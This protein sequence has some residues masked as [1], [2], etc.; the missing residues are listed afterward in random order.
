MDKRLVICDYFDIKDLFIKQVV[1]DIVKPGYL[2]QIIE[3]KDGIHLV[4]NEDGTDRFIY[5]NSL[6]SNKDLRYQ[7]KFT[8]VSP[9]NILSF[10]SEYPEKHIEFISSDENPMDKYKKEI[11][12][13]SL[14]ELDQP[15]EDKLYSLTDEEFII[16]MY[17]DL[18]KSDQDA[19]EGLISSFEFTSEA[20]NALESKPKNETTALRRLEKHIEQYKETGDPIEMGLAQLMMY[21]MF[22]IIKDRV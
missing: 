22:N 11:N 8:E 21:Y 1:G 3:D 17:S 6:N 2:Y 16:E 5:L 20:W 13:D 10:K 15:E 19:A 14:E 4:L 9:L 18:F 12:S 7:Y